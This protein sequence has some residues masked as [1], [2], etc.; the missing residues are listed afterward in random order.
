[1]DCPDDVS[2]AAWLD[3]SVE[4]NR[5]S[6]I[7]QHLDTCESCRNLFADVVR[8]TRGQTTLGRFV[9]AEPL[10]AG[11]MGEV[12]AA[13][14][15]KLGRRVALKL[16]RGAGEAGESRVQRLLREAQMMAQL[17][18]PNVV[19]VHEVGNIDDVPYIVM[20]HVDGTDLAAWRAAEPRSP[21]EIVRA[22][23]SVARG[24][25]A[26][27]EVGLV[28]RDVKP[29]NILIGRDGRARLGDFGL[30]G[31]EA[32]GSGAAATD[33]VQIT[34][35][36]EVVGTPAYMAPEQLRGERATP[37]SD[38]FALCV[39]LYELLCGERP[40]AGANLAE[41][42]KHVLAGELREPKVRLSA[43]VLRALRRGLAVDPAARFASVSALADALEPRASGRRGLA[44]A[45]IAVSAAAIAFV[46]WPR[47]PSDPCAGGAA[48][49]AATWNPAR[50]AVVVGAFGASGKPYAP[51]AVA[52][53]TDTLDAYAEAWIGGHRDA[54]VANRV[55]HVESDTRFDQRQAC[56]AE[57][58]R[59]L[60]ALVTALG[61]PTAGAIDHATAAA[62]ALPAVTD[63]AEARGLADADPDPVRHAELEDRAAAIATQIDLGEYAAAAAA[64][65][66]LVD[67]V[68]K[69]DAPALATRVLGISAM[70]KLRTGDAQGAE[71]SFRAALDQA[72]RA[73][74]DGETARVWGA[75]INVVGVL[76]HRPADALA[77]V[78]AAKLALVR[79][80]SPAELEASLDTN[81]G[82]VLRIAGKISEA[83]TMLERA[84]ALEP[85]STTALTNYAN[86]L[87]SQGHL[88]DALAID[89][90]L[91][92]IQTRAHG[93]D[94]PMTAFARANH[95]ALL[96]QT[97]DH[98][99]SAIE[100]R[101]ALAVL[102]PA[103][104]AED[105]HVLQ[106][107]N[108]LGVSLTHLG[109]LDDARAAFGHALAAEKRQPMFAA[110]ALNGL[111]RIDRT[112][113]VELLRHSLSL[114]EA[115]EGPEHPDVGVTLV[116]LGDALREQHACADAVPMFE[117]AARLLR[118]LRHDHP[119]VGHALA[120]QGLCLV[121][122]G[123]RGE[124]RAPLTEAREIA[125]ATK[126]TDVVSEIDRA[127]QVR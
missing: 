9:L 60:D 3:G 54:C 116:N 19:A 100:V 94:H 99:G 62:L 104:G 32:Q 44:I 66:P 51:A 38:Q 110:D 22:V 114:R 23:V 93:P 31:S 84:V 35:T 5:H 98:A 34:Q 30:A 1:L 115:S 123:R 69:L 108:N 95:A 118:A 4:G 16:P 82:A 6:E 24:L 49:L 92:A 10:G 109:K 40:F 11:A 15:P 46:A 71:A 8:A 68:G 117:R 59:R 67:E 26:V 106:L 2:V 39:L 76:E 50:R 7:E 17:S 63:C 18:H 29:S 52:R 83:R 47:T 77:M 125:L 12:H 91:V 36:G 42:T 20:E 73:H 97:G 120:G 88:D 113:A 13:I 28:H 121:E 57:R 86:V 78:D 96:D 127:L 80:G 126:Q 112:H 61:K 33:E 90:R 45:A 119:F 122:L 103:W 55:R 85:E 124:A 72:A 105:T 14:D 65:A 27:H 58:R 79:A 89:Q 37:A 43:R 101:T 102:E 48:E 107:W 87:T 41:L 74:A 64:I 21:T 53:V 75:L 111:A 81:L 56:L 70:A 25:A